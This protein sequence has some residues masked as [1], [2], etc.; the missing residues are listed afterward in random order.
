MRLAVYA[1]TSSD[2]QAERGTIENQLE[3][4]RKYADLHQLEIVK[5]YKDDGVT[6][7]IPLEARPAGHEL[8]QDAKDGMELSISFLS[9]A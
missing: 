1:R 8:L 9:T 6:G 3:F 5:W 4:A 7:T 2:D